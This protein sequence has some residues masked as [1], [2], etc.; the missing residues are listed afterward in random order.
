[1]ASSNHHHQQQ[2]YLNNIHMKTL[3]IATA[4]ILSVLSL[5]AKETPT[6]NPAAPEQAKA[7][8]YT[9]ETV[10]EQINSGVI[11]QLESQAFASIEQ[12]TRESTQL[13]A[14]DLHLGGSQAN[15]YLTDMTPIVYH[16]FSF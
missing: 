10:L 16:R 2:L 8:A 15:R 11:Q 1:L 5:N 7:P 12:E 6:G 3:T 14:G 4:L 9:V 13:I